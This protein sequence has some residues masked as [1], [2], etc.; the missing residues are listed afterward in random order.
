MIALSIAGSDPSGGSGVQRDLETFAALGVRGTSVLSCLTA[1][2]SASV[3][4]VMPLSA[5]FVA[6]QLD[7]LL[8]DMPPAATKTG[9]LGSAEVVELVAALAAAGRLGAFVVDPVL[10][11]SSGDTLAGRE[12]SEA[13]ALKL[14]PHVTLLT[15][16][17]HEAGILTDSCVANVDE[18]RRAG[19]VLCER[20]AGAVLVKGGHLPGPPTDILVTASGVKE[21][22]GE[23]IDT[24]EVR[25][26]GCALSAAITA[27][28]A[29][30]DRLD[31]A[32]AAGREYLRRGLWGAEAVGRGAWH[33]GRS[34]A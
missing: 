15:P 4:E 19:E 27:R 23:R 2:N 22:V 21:F 5:T 6:S 7:S 11:A 29:A 24:P 31:V 33:L 25:G 32:I 9:L 8:A 20:G 34:S 26:T 10:L 14:V 1:Q 28:L 17:L 16:N 12:V 3:A 18:M 30:G 13:I